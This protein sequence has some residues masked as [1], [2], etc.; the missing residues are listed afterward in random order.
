M[1]NHAYSKLGGLLLA[2]ALVTL[3]AAPAAAADFYLRA[4]AFDL[5]LPDGAV[6]PMWGYA[7]CDATFATCGAPSSPGPEL[8]VTDPLPAVVTIT[9]KNDLAVPTSIIMPAQVAALSPVKVTDAAGRAR[10]RSLAQETAP[11]ATGVYRWPAFRAGTFLY[12]SGSQPQV[13]VQM[14]LLG[15]VRA[16]AGAGLAYAGVPYDSEALVVYSEIDPGLHAAVSGGLYGTALYPSTFN[17]KPTYFLVNGA[18]YASGQSPLSAGAASTRVLLRLVN[19]ALTSRAPTLLGGLLD[20]VAENGHAYPFASR[21]YGLLLPAGSTKDAILVAPAAGTYPLYDRFLNLTSN[22]ATGGGS[23][24][25]LALGDPPAAR[26]A[27]PAAGMP[28]APTQNQTQ[29]TTSPGQSVRIRVAN[30]F[31]TDPRSLRILGRP[32]RGGKVVN[33]HDGTVTYS[34]PR[35]SA[36]Q[37]SFRYTVRLRRGGALL[38]GK[39]VVEVRRQLAAPRLQGR[40]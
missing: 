29:A 7:S 33:H 9:L 1:R 14:G 25:F 8:D 28:P 39:V 11:G 35:T 31:L 3:A 15:A 37:D 26:P 34:A 2:G 16:A 6:V 10:A 27:T 17:Y 21:G 24:A 38:H 36:V 30:V 32:A 19:G 20:V 12:H 13:Q 40:L 5:T 23:Y 4:A 18:P 22:Q